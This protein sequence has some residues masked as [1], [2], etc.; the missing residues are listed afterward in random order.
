M[1]SLDHIQLM[2]QDPRTISKMGL[3]IYLLRVIGHCMTPQRL[4]TAHHGKYV[5]ARR[6]A[7]QIKGDRQE[8]GG[9]GIQ[10]PSSG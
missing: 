10:R 2:Q 9:T 1:L 8:I 7:E 5:G 4:T 3:L 6:D